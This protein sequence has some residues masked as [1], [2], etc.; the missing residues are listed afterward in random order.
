MPKENSRVATVAGL[1]LAGTGLSHF[2]A[3][4]LY[5]DLTKQAFPTNTRQHVYIDGALET[6]V[7]L[8]IASPKTRKLALVGL[9]AY[10]GY[11]LANVARNR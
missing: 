8:G 7:G 9:V 10:L 1:A 3:P 11:M 6:A 5:E 2:V 4:H